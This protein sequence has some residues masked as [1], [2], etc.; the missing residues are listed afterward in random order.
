MRA[1]A[2]GF[3]QEG[4]VSPCGRWHDRPGTDGRVA[5]QAPM[6]AFVGALRSCVG[7]RRGARLRQLYAGTSGDAF[8][9]SGRAGRERDLAF[10]DLATT[11]ATGPGERLSRWARGEVGGAGLAGIS[12][13]DSRRSARGERDGI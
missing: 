3:A 13:C 9:F 4:V 5:K 1:V 10:R 8:A 11:H 12:T 7:G 2:G 6:P